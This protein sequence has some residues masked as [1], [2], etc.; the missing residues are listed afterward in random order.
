[1]KK[2]NPATLIQF[3]EGASIF[4]QGNKV[5]QYILKKIEPKRLILEDEKTNQSL[6]LEIGDEK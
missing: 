4:H 5:G 6:I 3:P 1:M 2:D